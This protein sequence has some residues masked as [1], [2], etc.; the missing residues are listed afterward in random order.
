MSDAVARALDELLP[1]RLRRLQRVSGLPVVFGG[2]TTAVGA[3]RHLVISRLAGTVGRSLRG[4]SVPSGRGLGGAVLRHGT[5]ACVN[6]YGTA[7]TIT[8][9]YDRIVV[10]EERI[11]SIVAVPVLVH[12]SVHGVLYG[13]VRDRQPIGERARRGAHAVAEQLRRDVER[14]LAAPEHAGGAGTAAQE[15]ALAELADI[16]AATGDPELRARL[17]RVYRGLH[18]QAPATVARLTDRELDV[19]RL[20]ATGATNLEAGA[21]LGLSPETVKA[22][23]RSAMRKLQARTRSAAV[24]SARSAGLL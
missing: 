3:E 23:L 5:S 4:L 7:K 18:P 1:E 16:I 10:G 8:H 11:V 9:E 21:E 2:G 12:G 17:R 13:A 6:D 24:H 22:Y 15:D 19:L 14:R 20:V